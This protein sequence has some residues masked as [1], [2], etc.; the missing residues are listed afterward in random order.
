MVAQ[1]RSAGDDSVCQPRGRGPLRQRP[2]TRRVPACFRYAAEAGAVTLDGNGFGPDPGQRLG[3][4]RGR[5]R[6]FQLRGSSPNGSGTMPS[7]SL[8]SEVRAPAEPSLATCAPPTG[9]RCNAID[10][11]WN[12]PRLP[13]IPL[14]VLEAHHQLWG[15]NFYLGDYKT[16]DEHAG[17]GMAIYDHE[18]HRHLAW[19]YTGH[20]PGVCCRSFLAQTLCICGKPDQAIQRSRDA[21][22][23]AERDSHPLSLAQAQMAASVVHL[24]RREPGEAGRLGGKGD[25]SMHRVRTAAFA[26]PVSRLLRLGACRPGSIG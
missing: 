13:G 17:H 16:S 8:P 19:G 18:R 26:W 7:Y 20:D 11:G 4:S 6:R 12:W 5:C 9:S 3:R 15:V 25:R 10:S 1:G 24:M 22:A 21:V 2:G 14:Y 23:L